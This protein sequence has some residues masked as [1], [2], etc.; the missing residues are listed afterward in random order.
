M[1]S[2]DPDL[3][4]SMGARQSAAI[5]PAGKRVAV[6]YEPGRAGS[7]A[8]ELG[9][10]LAGPAG[11]ALTVVSV[12]PQDTRVCCGA[13]SAIDYN[14]A[15]CESAEAE[16]RQSRKLLGPVAEHASF[17]VLVRDRDPPFAAWIAARDF[18]V[19]LLPA[20]QTPPAPHE[21]PGGRSATQ[22]DQGRRSAS[23]TLDRASRSRARRSPDRHRPARIPGRPSPAEHRRWPDAAEPGGPVTPPRPRARPSAW[24]QDRHPCP[25]PQ[26]A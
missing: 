15:V 22:V 6:L 3:L 21:A 1:T 11:R 14:R 2:L 17:K 19:V 16:L 12:A 23:S 9:R 24:A 18:D 7:A 5:R 26:P 10:R 8:L 4:T 20:R 25:A 13:G